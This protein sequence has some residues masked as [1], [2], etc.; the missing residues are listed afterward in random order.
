MKL[1]K[2]TVGLMDRLKY[3]Q[4]FGLIGGIL[5]IPILIMAFV[6]VNNMNKEIEVLETRINGTEYNDLLKHLLQDVQ[7]HRAL[8]VSFLSG[9]AS[10]ESELTKKQAE[11]TKDFTAIER[12]EQEQGQSF[13]TSD[14]LQK[15]K[16]KWKALESNI[17]NVTPQEATRL[18]VEYIQGITGFMVDIGDKSHLFLAKTP[19]AFYLID[20]ISRSLPNLTEELGQMRAIGMNAVANKAVTEAQRTQLVSL[21]SSVQF[22]LQRLEHGKTVTFTSEP[23][24][25]KSLGDITYSAIADTKKFLEFAQAELLQNEKIDIASDEYYKLATAT[26]DMNF[27]LYEEDS[28]QLTN[29]M[30]KQYEDIKQD[31]MVAIS[32]IALVFL[33]T[34]YC[35]VGFY[36]S[37]I[38]MVQKLRTV[39]AEV[40]GGDLTTQI[41]LNTK[42]EMKQVEISFNKMIQNIRQLVN[43]I[44]ANAVHV[45]SSSAELTASAEQT[46]SASEQ[47]SITIQEVASGAEK[48]AKSVDE[49]FTIVNELSAG[50]QQISANAQTVSV[51]A[52]QASS[53]ASSGEQSIQ[54]AAKQMNSINDSVNGAAQVV[55]NLGERSKEISNILDVIT[56][57]AA[58]TNLLALNA[59]IEAA[60]AG[61]LGKG[62]AVVAD[63][64]RK[65][66]EQSA[67]STQ[68]IGQLIAAIQDETERAVQSMGSVTKEV[69]EGMSVVQTAGTSFMEIQQSVNEAAEQIEQVSAAVQQM[70]AG[71]DQMVSSMGVI[72]EIAKEAAFGTQNVSAATEEQLA[73]MEEI[74]TSA[75][76]LNN[77][78]E[79]LQNE[80]SKFKI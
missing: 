21:S 14:A 70:A 78:A 19:H 40:A 4:K 27:K 74:G 1:F 80:I 31:R 58:Q 45:A 79:E 67:N 15:M 25:E 2:P 54:L 57:I 5:G 39:S 29:I 47:I 16:E 77:L 64:V 61:E 12:F 38:T 33:L 36:L 20:A 7:Q 43:Q 73:S 22:S 32:L 11:I 68:Q 48:Q 37:V 69:T 44:N 60:R 35:F 41:S 28:S 53:K 3:I 42:D 17:K 30:A 46:S 8:S 34:I 72:S 75:E 56:G 50:I 65:L 62:F 24:L 55:K 51:T 13:D 52:N 18:H 59:A 26:I 71:T 9:E 10:I 63:E 49:S 76:S 23:S 66:A 6:L